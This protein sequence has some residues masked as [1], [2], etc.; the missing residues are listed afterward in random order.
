MARD[1]RRQA[2][3][4]VLAG[5]GDVGEQIVALD[6]LEH[7]GGRGG[8]ERVAAE[9]RGV[10]HRAAGRRG[11]AGRRALGHR[12]GA[13][14]DAAAQALG[15][16]HHVGRDAVVLVAPPAAGAAGA[17]LHL[18]E[19]QQHAGGVARLAQ[20]AQVTVRR[21]HD[22]A[23]GLDR[24]EDHR[25]GVGLGDRRARGVEVAVRHELDRLE[26]RAEALAVLG[27]A[28]DRHRADRAAVEAADRGDDARARRLVGDDVLEP[29][30]QLERG[31]V[32]LAAGVGE[33]HPIGE[34]APGDG[35][36]G[37][38]LLVVPV[39]VGD[40]D[41]AAELCGEALGEL[42]VR[43][44]Q[45]AH[46]DAGGEIEVALVLDVPHLA[47]GAAGQHHRLLAIVLDERAIGDRE[48]VGLGVRHDRRI[49]TPRRANGSVARD[50]DHVR[51]DGGARA[52][53]S[54]PISTCCSPALA[55]SASTM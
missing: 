47:A 43:V 50:R 33:E 52:R 46:R 11:E 21:H 7:R 23:L 3:A 32:G 54:Q 40:V 28:G 42:G 14:R 26:Q 15:E 49:M 35:V 12:D 41:Q 31:L 44:T 9:R 10:G 13:D 36:G 38:D 30:R 5:G 55:R 37:E 22:A 29:A 45:A 53:C 34:R 20:A 4:E 39:Q 8:R 24:L 18:V 19:D 1:Q 25:A 2:L 27:L 48:E 16:R 51:L 17:G 6:Q